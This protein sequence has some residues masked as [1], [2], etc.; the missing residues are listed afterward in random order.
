MY[1]D[2]SISNLVCI[3]YL[4]IHISKALDVDIL[5]ILLRVINDMNR[6]F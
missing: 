2:E 5:A 4:S 6:C 1:T 3:S